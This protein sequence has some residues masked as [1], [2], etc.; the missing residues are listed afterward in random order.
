ML[1]VWRYLWP[2]PWTLIGLM[3]ALLVR[4]L[5][6]QWRR[7]D[8]ALESY[9]GGVAACC[10]RLPPVCRFDAITLGH[11]IVGMSG[12]ALDAARAHEHV[13]LRQYERWGL[14]FVPVYV[15]ASAWLWLRGGHPYRDNPF[16]QEAYAQGP[17]PAQ[18]A[19]CADKSKME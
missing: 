6:G 11:V 2:L 12:Q 7:V 3:V 15:G 5:G 18:A 8:G 10:E 16:E 13:H 1:Y 4:L 19:P 17:I 14:L 9:G